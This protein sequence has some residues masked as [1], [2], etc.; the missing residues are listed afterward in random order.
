VIVVAEFSGGMLPPRS[1]SRCVWPGG[2]PNDATPGSF[3]C[4]PHIAEQRERRIAEQREEFYAFRKA[5]IAK[6]RESIPE[7]YRDLTL[8]HARLPRLLAP[9]TWRR[10][11]RHA[12]AR[13]DG[14]I[15]RIAR[16][17]GGVLSSCVLRGPLT[18][19]GTAL[20]CAVLGTVLAAYETAEPKSREAALGN[21]A[22]YLS[23]GAVVRARLAAPHVDPPEVDAFVYAGFLVLD[24]L[25]S[26]A[27]PDRIADLLGERLREG[28]AT[29]VS[30]SLSREEARHRYADVGDALFQL[31]V[32]DLSASTASVP[33]E[34]AWARFDSPDLLSRVGPKEHGLRVDGPRLVA[35][36]REIAEEVLRGGRRVAVFAGPAGAGKT[37]L[38]VAVGTEIVERDPSRTFLFV[39]AFDLQN[40]E[41][42]QFGGAQAESPLLA[43][44]RS[45][46]VL[47]L[48]EAG[49]ERV[50]RD[51]ASV[52]AELL[53]YRHKRELVTLL[54]TPHRAR[55]LK[56]LWGDGVWRRVADRTRTHHVLLGAMKGAD[57]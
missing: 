40:E 33:G 39:D 47:V 18:A 24:G 7:P 5:G 15:G 49:A 6:S 48:D 46:D 13:A 29:V 12:A 27:K 38:A 54:T 2:C 41:H 30:T 32:L 34:Y 14:I 52:V 43:E 21:Q 42:R 35:E 37:S 1:G 26:E 19:G 4:E 8:D 16:S 22:A 51:R 36:A 25:G 20:G 44:A 23:A 45:V 53:H 56:E 3:L 10:S 50:P 28:R 31:P 9:D 17:D 11:E 55:Q 57:Q